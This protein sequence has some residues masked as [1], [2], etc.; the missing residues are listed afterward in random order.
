MKLGKRKAKGHTGRASK[1]RRSDYDSEDDEPQDAGVQQAAQEGEEADVAPGAGAPAEEPAAKAE[2]EVVAI[3]DADRDLLLADAKYVVQDSRWRNKERTLV[4]CRRGVSHRFRHLVEDLR[5]LMPHNK[6]EPKFDQKASLHQINQACELNTCNNVLFF[7]CR[8]AE[9]DQFMWLTRVPSGPSVEFQ[10]LN[11][12]TTGEVKLHGNCIL[13]SRPILYFDAAFD[14]LPHLR[15]MKALFTQALGTPR[16]HPKSKPYH[17]H[18]MGFY[19]LDHKIWFRN[20]Q[21]SP[22]VEYVGDDPERQML[23]EIGPRLVLD[24]I[25]VMAGSFSGAALYTNAYYTPPEK[26]RAQAK[27]LL[28]KPDARNPGTTEAEKAT[29]AKP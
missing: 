19:H 16:N 9:Q 6:T 8:N 2:P 26:L 11:I 28:K 20:Y 24:P 7:E 13:G 27:L 12:H 18:I 25:R 4:L 22:E 21:I 3:A 10:V 5:K 15:V 14:E 1:R 23:T 17:E 29:S